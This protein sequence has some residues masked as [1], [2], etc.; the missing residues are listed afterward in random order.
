MNMLAEGQAVEVA[1][2]APVETFPHGPDRP[3]MQSQV[4]A[5][6]AGNTW[7]AGVIRKVEAGG[8]YTV[9]LADPPHRNARLIRVP[10]SRL[11]QPGHR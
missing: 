4:V 8:Q 9:E 11:R 2:D 6:G 7:H 3:T 5:G 10:A 1:L